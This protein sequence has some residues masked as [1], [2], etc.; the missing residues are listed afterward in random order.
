MVETKQEVVIRGA[1][2]TPEVK[3]EEEIKSAYYKDVWAAAKLEKTIEGVRSASLST[4]EERLLMFPRG[5]LVA[6]VKGGPVVGYVNSCKWDKEAKDFSTYKTIIDFQENH[7]DNGKNLY[8]IFLGVD[9]KYRRNGIGSRLI[10]EIKVR[11]KDDGLDKVQLVSGD[12]FLPDFYSKL[13]FKEVKKLP[14]FLPY[15]DGT[16]MEYAVKK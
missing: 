15:I 13:G 12:D 1:S 6:E 10:E 16:L 7:S 4:L 5:F 8:V 14:N 2:L 9:T 11:A 3:Q